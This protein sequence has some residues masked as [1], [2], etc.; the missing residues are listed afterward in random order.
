MS[1][2]CCLGLEKGKTRW[3]RSQ[4]RQ[5]P[6]TTCIHNLFYGRR[7]VTGS[8]CNVH[9]G[10]AYCT[11]WS[12]RITCTRRSCIMYPEVWYSAHA[13]V[14]CRASTWSC[15]LRSA[16][17]S[18]G[19]VRALPAASGSLRVNVSKAKATLKSKMPAFQYRADQKIR[20]ALEIR[21]DQMQVKATSL[22]GPVAYVVSLEHCKS[23]TVD[24]RAGGCIERVPHLEGSQDN[25]A[26]WW[27]E[28]IN[29]IHRAD[30]FQSWMV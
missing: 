10:H 20:V 22:S 3:T 13:R 28:G 14:P 15:R 1:R 30:K 12:A 9:G 17:G 2:Q 27:G 6:R 24:A 23:N 16:A 18:P 5:I 19:L 26:S 29:L 11:R 4:K 25:V 8:V 7:A 21:V